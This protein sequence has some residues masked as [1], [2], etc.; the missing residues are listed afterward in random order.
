MNRHLSQDDMPLFT[1]LRM[2]AFGHTVIELANDPTYDDW[3]V[4]EKIFH[5]LDTEL[6][7]RQERRTQKLLKDSR[8]P[9]PEACVEE[10]RYLPRATS[11]VS[12]SVAWPVVNG[13]TRPPTW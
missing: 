3:T 12:T 7:A 5:A 1:Q 10:I 13:S 11:I 8:S 6:T 2:T 4:P 9:N